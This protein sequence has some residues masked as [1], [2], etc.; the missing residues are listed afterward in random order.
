[1]ILLIHFILFYFQNPY[2]WTTAKIKNSSKVIFIV[3]VNSSLK[4]VSPI[5]EQWNHALQYITGPDFYNVKDYFAVV[6]LP[7]SG[8]V[9]YQVIAVKN[10]FYVEASE[11]EWVNSQNY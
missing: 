5:K 10:K 3:P 6:N 7:N 11:E 8:V 2:E 9:P 1:M 4:S